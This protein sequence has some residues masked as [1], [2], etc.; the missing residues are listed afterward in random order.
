MKILVDVSGL[1]VRPVTASITATDVSTTLLDES[2]IDEQRQDNS[3]PSSSNRPMVPSCSTSVISQ[4]ALNQT[5]EKPRRDYQNLTQSF[6]SQSLLESP[7]SFLEHL[8]LIANGKPFDLRR[9]TLSE[10]SMPSP[11]QLQKQIIPIDSSVVHPQTESYPVRIV[12]KRPDE[13]SPDPSVLLTSTA[14]PSQRL[15]A[16]FQSYHQHQKQ[17]VNQ[18]SLP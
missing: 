15:T 18:H 11:V 9:A 1:Q 4:P 2:H 12:R 10:D 8:G 3:A 5:V 13:P 17:L 14:P 7:S 6:R 16:A